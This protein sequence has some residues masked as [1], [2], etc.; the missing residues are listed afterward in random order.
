MTQAPAFPMCPSLGGPCPSLNVQNGFPGLPTGRVD[1]QCGVGFS[2]GSSRP[3]KGHPTTQRS[4]QGAAFSLQRAGP[5]VA[6]SRPSLP[7]PP[8]PF[9]HLP[10]IP[11]TGRTHRQSFFSLR[12]GIIKMDYNYLRKK[13]IFKDHSVVVLTR[14]V[15][16][17]VGAEGGSSRG[18]LGRPFRTGTAEA[19][20]RLP[21]PDAV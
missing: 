20:G 6:P 14:S 16:T 3:L 13:N 19:L 4:G 18:E 5:E 11:T 17:A 2:L 7:F 12:V 9:N 21:P 15:A 8:C 1:A 10:T